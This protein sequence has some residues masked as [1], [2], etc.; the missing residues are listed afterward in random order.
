[1]WHLK[2]VAICGKRRT[3]GRIKREKERKDED[4]AD[5]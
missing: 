4:Q 2:R 3:L 1:V 5:V